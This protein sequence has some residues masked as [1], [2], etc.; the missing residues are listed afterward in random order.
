MIARR[1]DVSD[2]SLEAP[3]ADAAEQ[4]ATAVPADT[5]DAGAGDAVPVTV[6]LEAD[7]ADAA[8]QARDLGVDDSEEYR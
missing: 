4:Q 6:P 1:R 7:S 8:E 3:E 5:E 2:D